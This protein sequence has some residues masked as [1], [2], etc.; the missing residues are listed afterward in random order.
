MPFIASPISLRLAQCLT[1]KQSAGNL[2][3][4]LQ[5]M[6]DESQHSMN[7]PRIIMEQK[8]IMDSSQVVDVQVDLKVLVV[9]AKIDS[10]NW[11]FGIDE[12]TI[13]HLE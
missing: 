12:Q 7:I 8:G 9:S 5:T 6:I 1:N 4:I 3:S 13:F 2:S 10:Q 11:D